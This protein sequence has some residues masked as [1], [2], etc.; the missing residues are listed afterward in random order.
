MEKKKILV[1]DDEPGIV[2]V[3]Q[4]RLEQ[5]GYKV[6]SAYD[7]ESGLLKMKEEKPDLI[8]LDIMMPGMDGYQVCEEIKTDPSTE[9]IPVIILTAKNMGDDFDMAMEKR[10][11]WYITKPY[12]DEHLLKRI[13]GLI[14]KNEE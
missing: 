2:K 3:L 4:I 9:N 10:A 12:N 6:V 7:G 14:R 8:V 1:I 11:D 5:A 13:D